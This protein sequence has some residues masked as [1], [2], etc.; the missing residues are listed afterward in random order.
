V[1]A[2]STPCCYPRPARRAKAADGR[3]PECR[4]LCMSSR[5]VTALPLVN[6]EICLGLVGGSL[7]LRPVALTSYLQG[8]LVHMTTAVRRRPPGCTRRAFLIKSLL[9]ARRRPAPPWS[10]PLGRYGVARWARSSKL[11][12]G[13]RTVV[14]ARRRFT[15]PR[16]PGNHLFWNSTRLYGGLPKRTLHQRPGFQVSVT[17][18]EVLA[19]ARR[20]IRPITLAESRFSGVP[21]RGSEHRCL[22]PHPVAARGSAHV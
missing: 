20:P 8:L 3:A 5:P 11:A 2:E 14:L 12:P 15:S 7:G 19:D 4:T 22:V 10:L 13:L 6:L 18:L 16:A 1:C 17:E 9:H 21:P